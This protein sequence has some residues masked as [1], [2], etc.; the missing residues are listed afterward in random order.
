[1]PG[2]AD[3][4]SRAQHGDRAALELLCRQ[5]WVT[6]YRVVA[7][8]VASR[9]EAEDLTQEVFLRALRHLEGYQSA[10]G[11]FRPYLIAVA[12]NLVRDRW[13][14][15]QRQAGGGYDPG[16]GEGRDEGPE[17]AVVAAEDRAELIAALAQLPFDYQ[18]VLRL[19]LIEGQSAAEV[20][21]VL[22]RSPEAVRQLQHRALS[23]LRSGLASER[24]QRVTHG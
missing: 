14:S 1:V 23:A 22:E 12:R 18:Q 3:L 8:W 6:V 10:S 16:V 4:L 20:A 19:R 15:Q 24:E 13:R 21:A 11:S 7:G 17:A 2:R 9:Q 5:E